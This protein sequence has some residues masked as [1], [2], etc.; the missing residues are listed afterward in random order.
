MTKTALQYNIPVQ[1]RIPH[2]LHEK[3]KKKSQKTGVTISFVVRLAL[4]T[5]VKQDDHADSK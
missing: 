2:D 4:E 5:W 3:A 1:V